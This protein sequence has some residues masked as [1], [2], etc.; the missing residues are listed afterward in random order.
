MK[1]PSLGPTVYA[2]GIAMAFLGGLG[3]FVPNFVQNFLVRLLIFAAYAYSI[4]LITGLTGYVSFGHV[5]FVGT[6]AY[7]L[8]FA[9]KTWHVNPILGVALA[10]L[11]GLLLAIGLGLVTLRFRGVYFAIASLVTVLAAGYIVVTIPQLNAGQGI[12]MIFPFTPVLYFYTIWVLVAAEMG[13]TYWVT[14]GR[15]GLGIRAIRGDED[16]AKAL[17]VN[18]AWLKLFLFSL[19]GF[20]AGA[21]GAVSA[22]NTY[23][24]FPDVFSL[25]TSLQMLAMIV[26]GGMG[27]LLG[28]LL[29]AVLVYVPSYVFVT[30]AGNVQLILV[31]ALVVFFALVIPSG[32]VGGLRRYVPYLR[33]ILE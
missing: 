4:N 6:G 29:G 15:L 28:P 13:L 27:T 1:M 24:V 17:G 26:V 25:T 22:W 31:G 20:F 16:A 14:H 19:S 10:G 7:A 11:A 9:F 32:L 18:A 21:A 12:M 8:G 3:P 30:T 23:G 5:V 2:L 33:R